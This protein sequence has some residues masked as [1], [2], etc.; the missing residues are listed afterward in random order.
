MGLETVDVCLILYNPGISFLPLRGPIFSLKRNTGNS[1]CIIML[2]SG[3]KSSVLRKLV[4][5]YSRVNMF[6][7]IIEFSDILHLKI[8][9]KIQFWTNVILS[10]LIFFYDMFITIV[11]FSSAESLL[12]HKVFPRKFSC[13]LHVQ[14]QDPL[15]SS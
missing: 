13:Q 1:L 15:S 14:L 5:F 8:R 3:L 10:T 7:F 2:R 6:S 12:V 11:L 9:Q 4:C